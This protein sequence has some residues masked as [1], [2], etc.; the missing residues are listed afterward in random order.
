MNSVLALLRYTRR[1]S[2]DDSLTEPSYVIQVRRAVQRRIFLPRHF[3]RFLSTKT[4]QHEVNHGRVKHGTEV[5]YWVRSVI[6]RKRHRGF[7]DI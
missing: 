4:F 5:I 6:L 3:R 2:L 1:T 7:E